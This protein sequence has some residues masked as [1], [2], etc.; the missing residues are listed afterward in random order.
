MTVSASTEDKRESRK[1][2]RIGVCYIFKEQ[3]R[4][5]KRDKLLVNEQMI[6]Q[7]LGQ[8]NQH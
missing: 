7:Q 8:K 1:K 4:S 2:V 6:R 5:E 3:K